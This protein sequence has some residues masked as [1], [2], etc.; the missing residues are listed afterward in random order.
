MTK[1]YWEKFKACRSAEESRTEAMRELNVDL[2]RTRRDTAWV[3][4]LAGKAYYSQGFP[5]EGAGRQ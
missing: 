5:D 4:V 1:H 2:E 3:H